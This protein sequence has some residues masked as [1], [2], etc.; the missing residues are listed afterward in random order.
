[1]FKHILK[2]FWHMLSI[3]L[4]AAAIFGVI[5]GMVWILAACTA[6]QVCCIIGGLGVALM[7]FCAVMD[8]RAKFKAE[9]VDELE[10]CYLRVCRTANGKKVADKAVED[11]AL[12]MVAELHNYSKTF[13]RD[14]TFR[15]YADRLKSVIEPLGL[16]M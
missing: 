9:Q 7:V 4:I 6:V 1:M 11:A 13:G 5:L 15:S 10:K 16:S 3:L 14:D 12:I 2:S 8:G